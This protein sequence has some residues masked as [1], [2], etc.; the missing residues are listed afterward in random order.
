MWSDDKVICWVNKVKQFFIGFY[1]WMKEHA[2]WTKGQLLWLPVAFY[3][4]KS[5]CELKNENIGSFFSQVFFLFIF[6][7]V[8]HKNTEFPHVNFFL[9]HSALMSGSHS[10]ILSYLSY[11]LSVLYLFL[12]CL[13]AHNKISIEL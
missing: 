7:I 9:G 2:E 1:H 13:C 8:V 10:L 3:R 5:T 6:F 11:T 4:H 12:F